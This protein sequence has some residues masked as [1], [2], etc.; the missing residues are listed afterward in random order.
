M[1]NTNQFVLQ[2]KK[3]TIAKINGNFENNKGLG[4][5]EGGLLGGKTDCIK[6]KG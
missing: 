4:C 2:L 1:K 6:T 3:T 5:S